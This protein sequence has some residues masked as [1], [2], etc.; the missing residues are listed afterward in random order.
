[1]G[2]RGDGHLVESCFGLKVVLLFLD[3]LVPNWKDSW[4]RFFFKKKIHQ[5]KIDRG[6]LGQESTRNCM[7][8]DGI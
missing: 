2:L 6:L 4:K 7:T 5:A 8:Y 1:M 3:F